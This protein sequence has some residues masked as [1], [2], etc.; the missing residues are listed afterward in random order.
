MKE[1]KTNYPVR[2]TIEEIVKLI[3]SATD[4]KNKVEKQK[5]D[6]AELEHQIEFKY[7]DM[8]YV[9][10]ERQKLR[11][12]VSSFEDSVSG[13]LCGAENYI[14]DIEGYVSDA[15]YSIEDAQSCVD[16]CISDIETLLEES[17]PNNE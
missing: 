17:D 6:I 15:Q 16:N 2:Y 12:L 14:G 11:N 4:L 5:L 9:L 13:G 1:S 10:I 7:N 3:K 8:K